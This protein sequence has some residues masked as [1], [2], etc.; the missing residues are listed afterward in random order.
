ME[1][2]SLLR[3][4]WGTFSVIDHQNPAM[5]VPEILL[6]DRLVFPIPTG[7]AADRAHWEKW[8]PKLQEER[9]K[10]LEGLIHTVPWTADLHDKWTARYERFRQI[11]K[12]TEG[13]AMG[14]TPVVLATSVFVDQFPPPIMIAAYQDATLAQSDLELEKA[15][16]GRS[17]KRAALD[18]EVRAL[19]E[20]RLDMPVVTHPNRTYEKAIALARDPQYQ[21]ARRSLFEWEDKVLAAGWSVD[22][23]VKKL[24]HLVEAH[25][26]LIQRV[27][28]KTVER[29]VFRVTEFVVAPLV[30]HATH[31]EF[32]GLAASG[33]VKMI[34]ARLPVLK[35]EPGDP[36]AQPG[37][38]LH[39]AISV[40]FHEVLPE[41]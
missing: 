35:N 32:A 12:E 30:S 10:E 18:N 22:D 20:R 13:I 1:D 38:A 26:E 14:L 39:R 37:A 33:I 41:L 40:M 23:A 28:K 5:L 3:P 25:D 11:G 17:P 19:F 2:E 16:G 36:L 24:E 31:N 29:T 15:P 21:R 4:R 6:Y 27:F 9:L 8:N 34:G 7:G